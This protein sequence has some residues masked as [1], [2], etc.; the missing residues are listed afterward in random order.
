MSLDKYQ[1][2]ASIGR[3]NRW[4]QLAKQYYAEL[5]DWFEV[6]IKTIDQKS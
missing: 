6:G 3:R 2:N 5:K 4:I 1:I